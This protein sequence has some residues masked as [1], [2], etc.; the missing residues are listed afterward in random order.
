WISWWMNRLPLAFQQASVVG[1]LFIELL[2]PVLLLLPWRVRLARSLA[3]VGCGG[4]QLMIAWTGN[5]GFFNVLALALS[6][7]LIDDRVWIAA[8]RRR[9]RSLRAQTERY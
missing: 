9:W 2:L 6:L 3:A 7:A 4:L 1:M 5:Y 8:W